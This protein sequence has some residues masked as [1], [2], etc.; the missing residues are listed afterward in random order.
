VRKTYRG[1][2]IIAG[3]YVFN[4]TVMTAASVHHIIE[5]AIDL[6]SQG[7]LN[8]LLVFSAVWMSRERISRERWDELALPQLLGRVYYPF[9]G[10]GM[11]RVVDAT[12]KKPIRNALVS[13]RREVGGKLLPAARKL[14]NERG[15]YYF[16]G[17]AGNGKKERVAYEIRI[18]SE[19]FKPSTM[20]VHLRAGE[21]IN[22]GDARLKLQNRGR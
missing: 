8:S 21:R 13:V 22:L 2:E 10:E 1:K 9:L 20:R 17:W 7:H 6:Y 18:E 16:G 15:E 12:T 4:G 19:S 5:H 14:T 11:G 3:V